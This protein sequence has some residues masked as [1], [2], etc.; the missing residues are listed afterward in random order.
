M[1]NR[2]DSAYQSVEVVN[3]CNHYISNMPRG[4]PLQPDEIQQIL[5]VYKDC[6]KRGMAITEAYKRVADLTQRDYRHIG[7]VI[8]RLEPTTDLSKMYLRAKSYRLVK[9]LVKKANTTEII[10]ILSR[11]D[12]GVLAP[13]KSIE[14]GPTGFFLSVKADTCGAVNVGVMQGTP[15][16]RKQLAEKPFDDIIDV[17]QGENHGE[18]GDAADA[19]AAYREEDRAETPVIGSY[20]TV[21]EKAKRKLTEARERASHASNQEVGGV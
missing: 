20:E 7:Q 16:D 13:A 19:L 9:R 4:Q 15:A 8:R 1:S 18:N 2:Q 21:I 14:Q 12:I 17:G 11:P 5:N 6:R 10:D 3:R